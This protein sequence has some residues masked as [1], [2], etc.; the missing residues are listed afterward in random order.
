MASYLSHSFSCHLSV[1]M[2]PQLEQKIVFLCMHAQILPGKHNNSTKREGKEERGG[3]V[4][5]T[6]GQDF[7]C[8]G[9]SE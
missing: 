5:V 3:E 8:T 9:E 2:V 1:K 6:N 4:M 7:G